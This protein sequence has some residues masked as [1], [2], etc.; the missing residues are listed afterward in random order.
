[1]KTTRLLRFYLLWLLIGSFITFSACSDDEEMGAI[2]VSF[3]LESYN[4]AENTSSPLEVKITL[5]RASN[6]TLNFPFTVAGSAVEGVDYQTISPRSVSFAAGATEAVVTISPINNNFVETDPRTIELTLSP[7]SQNGLM[8]GANAS[9]TIN[10]IND[11]LAGAIIADF[12]AASLVTNEYLKQTV[13]LKV[14]VNTP[15]PEEIVLE[16]TI[17]GDAVA[18]ENY[19]ALPGTTVTIPM[20]V[21]SVSIPVEIKDTKSYGQ[22]RSITLSL[23]APDNTAI[24][25]GANATATVQIINPNAN[26]GLWAKNID[27]PT[28]YAYN[29]YADV[30]VPSSG[31]NQLDAAAGIVFRESFG[32]AWRSTRLN[33]QADPNAIDF[34][35]NLW[36]EDDFTRSTNAFNMHRLY[37]FDEYGGKATGI[38]AASAGVRIIEAIRLVPDGVNSKTGIAV[39]PKQKVRL[40]F[41]DT[42]DDGIKNPES[43]EIEISGEGTYDEDTGVIKMRMIFDETEI[44]NGIKTRR[45]EFPADRRPTS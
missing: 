36:T 15:F 11:D 41:P 1:M 30:E 2:L 18:G 20:G 10:I 28:L 24:A 32:F 8:L 22:V 45:F 21:T 5:S 7:I 16:Y 39:V 42:T 12:E 6:T 33:A 35:S 14:N 9:T 37:G 38:S 31:R 25:I 44:D 23:E 4:V 43:F 29:T 40:Y 3:E 17:G 13:E 26:I 27:F 19:T 34:Y